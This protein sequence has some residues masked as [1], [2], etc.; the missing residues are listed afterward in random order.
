MIG[1]ENEILEQYTFG[2]ADF[3]KQVKHTITS[4]FCIASNSKTFTAAAIILLKDRGAIQ[5][6]D[7]VSKYLPDF[8][9]G[10]QITILNLL[11]YESGLADIDWELNRHNILDAKALVSEI[12]KK[13][14][15]FEPGTDGRYG[16]AGFTI[17]ARVVETVSGQS[18]GAFLKENFF[19]TYDMQHTGDLSTHEFPKDFS[20]PNFPG[21]R[22]ELTR[23]IPDVNY[24]LSLGSG[25]MYSSAIDLWK[26][27]SSIASKNS[28][29][30][31]KEAYPYGWG[32]DSIAGRFCL[33]QTGMNNGF[34][35]SL[36]I[37][38][39]EKVTMVLLSNIEN[40]LWV[41]WTKDL[42]KIYFKDST[43]TFYPKK[44]EDTYS[45]TQDFSTYTGRFKLNEDRII[46][47][48]N[49]DNDLY[50]HLNDFYVGHHL[51]PIEKDK[52]ELR[53][54]TGTLFFKNKDSIHW[55]LPER[56][57]GWVQVYVRE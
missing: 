25:S 12:E 27:G 28:V 47:I 14:L 46:D 8:K 45:P 40:G 49:V 56:W 23:Y 38:P 13:P 17:L 41:D 54:F 4:T 16:N 6:N 15:E 30:V 52:F 50:L 1:N 24:S 26:W 31:F 22:P 11:R 9:Y 10:D 5:F 21:P 53:S 7:K 51:L 57:G 42:A 48:K 3:E 43:D 33:N 34:V 19:T 37:F 18:Y 35:S 44:R 2:Y 29:N 39:E 55:K 32:R 36:F 20:N